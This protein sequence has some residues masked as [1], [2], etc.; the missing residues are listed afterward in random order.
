MT[1]Y[2]VPQETSPRATTLNDFRVHSSTATAVGGRRSPVVL[3]LGVVMFVAALGVA[4]YV[5]MDRQATSDA[6]GA[7][8]GTGAA[9]PASSVAAS[10]PQ[11]TAQAP[12]PAALPA[13]P[14][15]AGAP[16]SAAT[17]ATPKSAA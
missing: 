5:Y 8:A 12:A 10:T 2:S 1:N 7:V 3:G 14:T 17:D 13:T 6:Q 16:D 9:V 11:M 15:P 4:G